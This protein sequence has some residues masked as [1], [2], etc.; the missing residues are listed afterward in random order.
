MRRRTL[1]VLAAFA[2]ALPGRA[3]AS[4]DKKK[5]AGGETYIQIET[6]TAYTI[7]ASGRRGVM[8]VDCGLD[9]PDANLR[10]RTELLLP[11]LRAGYVQSLQI[12]AGGLP[13]DTAPDPAFLATSLQRVTDEVLGRRGAR[14]L[15]GAV[16]VN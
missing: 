13:P 10:E 6:L 16:L 1:L 3:P 8:T 4:E 5:K 12:Y 11:R 15:V 7:R 14:L 9:V 2:C